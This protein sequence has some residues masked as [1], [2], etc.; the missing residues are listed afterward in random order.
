MGSDDVNLQKDNANGTSVAQTMHLTKHL[1]SEAKATHLNKLTIATEI[2]RQKS[3]ES[4]LRDFNR[5]IV[6]KSSFGFQVQKEI[7][8]MGMSRG[9]ESKKTGWTEKK[10][11]MEKGR[12]MSLKKRKRKWEKEESEKRN[13]EENCE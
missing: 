11:E 4:R 10:K 5:V 1:P 7:A 12:K 8:L 2:E 6:K 9:I 13:K 3:F